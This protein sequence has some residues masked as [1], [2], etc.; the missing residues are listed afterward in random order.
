MLRRCGFTLLELVIVLFIA[1]LM[2]SLSAVLFANTLS[3]SRL[4]ATARDIFSSIRQARSLAQIHSQRQTVTI[5]LDSRQ[6]GIEGHALKRIPSDVN[7]KV[8][9]PFSGEV[10]TGKYQIVAGVT[11][12]VNGGTI[13]LWNRKKTVTI[14]MDPVLGAVVSK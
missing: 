7:I 6:F 3:S 4:S 5:D 12:A 2:V 9:D 13:V 14:Q 11:G 1:V 10:H 8:N